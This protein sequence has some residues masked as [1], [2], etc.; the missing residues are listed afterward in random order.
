MSIISKDELK[1]I[2]GGTGISG[3]IINAFIKGINEIIEAGKL[4]GSAIRRIVEGGICNL[5]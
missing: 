4:C 1:K 3:T 2:N 5:E